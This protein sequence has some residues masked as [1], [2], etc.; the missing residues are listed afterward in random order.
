MILSLT[1]LTFQYPDTEIPVFRTL[2]F[3]LDSPGFHALFGASGVGKTSFARIVAGELTGFSGQLY[4]K[5]KSIVLY[6]YNQERLPGWGTI[7][8]FIDSTTPS[9]MIEMKKQLIDIFGLSDCINL[10][11]SQLSLGQ[12]NRVNLIRYLLQEFDLLIMDESLANVDERL[13]E[14]IILKIK[15]SFPDRYFLYIS[16][17][18]MEITKFS[19]TILIFRDIEKIPQTLTL[20][21]L[22]IASREMPDRDRLE[23]TV[24]EVMN[25]C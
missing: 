5:D 3:S 4:I 23:T 24:L 17:N 13:R 18:L 20:K 11:F 9:S 22:D 25:A 19:D 7:R 2:N 14:T 21:G 12:K 1:N 16:H 10:R 15:E 8:H 6:S